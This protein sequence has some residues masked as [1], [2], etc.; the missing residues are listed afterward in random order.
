[1]RN[2]DG[3][4]LTGFLLLESLSACS[5]LT[6]HE[7]FR[8]HV[9]GEL[10]RRVDE[11]DWNISAHLVNTSN[12][13]NGHVAYTYRYIRSCRV[14]FEVIPDTRIIVATG[15]EGSENDCVISP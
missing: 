11:T 6:P 9:S 8:Q 13:P 2:V 3:I 10:G 14:T 7:N 1:M 4:I 12:M 15:W 5:V